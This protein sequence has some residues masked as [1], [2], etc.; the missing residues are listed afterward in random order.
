MSL[1]SRG[2]RLIVTPKIP[3]NPGY[4]GEEVGVC[5]P[6]LK[7]CLDCL[8]CPRP[9]ILDGELETDE[10]WVKIM[11]VL[12]KRYCCLQQ[13]AQQRNDDILVAKSFGPIIFQT[14]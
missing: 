3:L 9:E 4:R 10:L 7:T 13:M 12:L 11:V 8:T 14:Q 6:L 2:S 1:T 5:K